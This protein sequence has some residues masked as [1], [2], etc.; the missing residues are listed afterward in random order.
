MWS[1]AQI[2]V[3]F[4]VCTAFVSI[5]IRRS[6]MQEVSLGINIY[7]VSVEKNGWNRILSQRVSTSVFRCDVGVLFSNFYAQ[8]HNC[9]KIVR[10]VCIC[11]TDSSVDE[12]ETYTLSGF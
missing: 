2:S 12:S 6:G 3:S 11:I 9:K 7:I 5:V 10:Q 4:F 8:E 1:A